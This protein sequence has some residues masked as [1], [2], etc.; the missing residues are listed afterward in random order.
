MSRPF[1]KE[2]CDDI[3]DMCDVTLKT[4]G[5]RA[6]RTVANLVRKIE[7]YLKEEPKTAEQKENPADVSGR[8]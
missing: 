1:T 3:L 5:M 2:D 7:D 6:F 8:P 4:H